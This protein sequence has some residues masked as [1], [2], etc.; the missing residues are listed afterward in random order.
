VDLE[1]VKAASRQELAE[2]AIAAAGNAQDLLQDAD[3]RH[4]EALP[5]PSGGRVF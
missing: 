5:C 1:A 4:D 2:C 3:P